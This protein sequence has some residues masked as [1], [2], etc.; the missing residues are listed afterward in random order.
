MNILLVSYYFPPMGGAGVQRALK[1]SKYLGDFGVR[2][3]VLAAH[4]PGYLQDET[5]LADVP[6]GV[7]VLRVPHQAPLQR[8]LA[9]RARAGRGVAP[10]STAMTAAA[11]R[12]RLRDAALTAYA[13]AHFPDDKAAWAR[14]AHV[15]ARALLRDGR[16]D[17]ILSTAPP[18]SAHALASKL[19]RQAGLPWVADYRDLWTENPAYAAPA[20]RRALDRRTEAAW[21]R[22]AAGVVTVTPSWQRML[23]VRLGPGREV[24]FIPNG[25]DEADFAALP[26]VRRD[27]KVFR[28]VHTGAFYGPRDPGTLLDALTLYLRAAPAGARPLRLRL[29]GSMGSRFADRL[30]A[31]EARHP[32]V[33]EQRPYVP[34]HEALAEML[35]A[36]ALLLVVGVG[37]GSRGRATVVGTLPGK[38]FEYLRAAR[39]VLLLGDEAGDAAALLRQHGRGWVADETQPAAI[40]AALRQMMQAAP[41]A[42]S[43]PAASVAKFERR[44][45]A[46]ELAQFLRQCIGG[47]QP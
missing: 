21:L 44:A 25:Y 4:D 2:A 24:A 34:H 12:H 27:D 36:D 17:L 43:A 1:F 41:E 28:L 18:M 5:L 37:D 8:L 7:P 9:W 29:V 38:I 39:P 40:A 11:P 46:G 33:V 26:P 42:P 13:S 47:R 32:G 20:W 3:T 31:F 6:A 22:Q 45:L 14:R 23:A 19:A 35:A 15:P 16:F 10:A 30:R